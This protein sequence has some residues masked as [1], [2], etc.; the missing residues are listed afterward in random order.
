M[1]AKGHSILMIRTETH[2]SPSISNTLSFQ[3]ISVI[4]FASVSSQGYAISPTRQRYCLYNENPNACNYGVAS[5]CLPC[6]SCC[7]IN[8]SSSLAFA[9][10]VIAFMASVGFLIGE[11]M[12]EQ[13]SSVKSRKHYVLA[14]MAFHFLWAFMF[15][16][17]FCYL[18]NQ[19]SASAEPPIGYSSTSVKSA[20][21]FCL[22]GSF[23]CVSV[24]LR[25]LQAKKIR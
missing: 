8:R 20:I 10:G 4:V 2:Q 15:F 5:E 7:P 17:G 13:M 22:F 3:V 24:A 19:W 14:D 21:V 25:A 12:F 23:S 16:I 6:L 11:Y 18:T 9:V 1:K